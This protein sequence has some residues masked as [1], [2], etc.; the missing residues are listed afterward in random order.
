MLGDSAGTPGDPI[1]VLVIGPSDVGLSVIKQLNKNSRF[2]IAWAGKNIEDAVEEHEDEITFIRAIDL[3]KTSS[4]MN[5]NSLIEEL[6]PDLV[7]LCQRGQDWNI[8]NQVASSNLERSMLGESLR[9]AE[10]PVITVSLEQQA[11]E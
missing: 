9:I 1:Q 4:P 11:T 3:N 2:H 7:F 10:A 5:I 6:S 8:E